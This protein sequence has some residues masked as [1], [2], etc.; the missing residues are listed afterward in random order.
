MNSITLTFCPVC[1][2]CS[3]SLIVDSNYV[4]FK[5]VVTL[6]MKNTMY[7]LVMPYSQKEFTDG[8]EQYTA[9]IY[10]VFHD[11]RA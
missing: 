6:H 11:F 1:V 5:V 9:S 3:L 8:W 10:K 7:R 4:R 2:S